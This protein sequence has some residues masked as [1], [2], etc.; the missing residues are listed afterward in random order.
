MKSIKLNIEDKIFDILKSGLVAKRITG[1]LY[2]VEDEFLLLIVK[3]IL[4]GQEEITIIPKKKER[5]KRLSTMEGPH[6]P[7]G[8]R[9]TELH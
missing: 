2:G 7:N 9:E 4:D 8:L 3:S 5:K 1:S 6:S